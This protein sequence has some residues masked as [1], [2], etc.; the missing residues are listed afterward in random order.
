MKIETDQASGIVSF[1]LEGRLD[2]VSSEKAEALIMEAIA[3]EG[4]YLYDLSL[5]GYISSAGL[6][7]LLATTKAIRHR[8]G[9]FVMCAPNEDI[10]H[11]L[12]ISGFASLFPLTDTVDEGRRLL[13]DA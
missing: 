5:L 6:R 13:T 3:D 10:R 2:A 1:I 4:R 8:E 9:R 11:I 7:V 12:D